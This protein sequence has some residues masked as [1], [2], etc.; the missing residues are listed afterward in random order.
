MKEVSLFL[1]LE[2]DEETVRASFSKSELEIFKSISNKSI[3]IIMRDYIGVILTHELHDN[4]D[5]S[6]KLAMVGLCMPYEPSKPG[7]PPTPPDLKVT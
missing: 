2:V 4:A 1:K 7:L 3:E 5:I 6:V